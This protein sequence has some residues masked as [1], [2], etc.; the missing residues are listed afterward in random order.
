M[1]SGIS[2]EHPYTL[3]N[4]P[5]GSGKTTAISNSIKKLLETTEKRILCITFTNRATEQLALKIED[6]RVDI[7][8][9]HSFV[10]DI[11]VPF[12]KKKE[13]LNLYRDL[14][15][16]KINQIFNSTDRKDIERIE[17]Y[18]N[19]KNIS[20]EVNLDISIVINNL[21]EIYYNE[22]QFSSY[23]YGGLSHDDLLYFAKEVFH[24]FTKINKILSQKYSHIF[25]D[26]YQDTKS[27]I[28][29]LFYNATFGTSTRLILM[30]D[31]MQQIYSDSVEEFQTTLDNTFYKDTSL[32][33]NWRS[34]KYI[35]TVLNNLYFDAT[36]K[37]EPMQKGGQLPTIHIVRNMN[38]IEVLDGALQLVLYNSDMFDFIGSG[39][40]FRAF[41][42]K[43]KIY[44]K[45]S[46]KQ[47]LT[48]MSMENP[49]ELMIVLIFITDIVEL[50]DQNKFGELI[51]RVTEFRHANG[52]IWKINKHSDKV[53][54]QAQ[55]QEL[56]IVVKQ[57]ISLISLLDY[58]CE[59]KIINT[60][61]IE[62]VM[63]NINENEKFKEKI[64]PVK[65]IQFKNCYN[66]C[67]KQTI[68]TQHAV[69]G[70]GHNAVL[71]KISDGSNP[72]IQMYTF[73]ELWS[74][75]S[76]DYRNIK[77]IQNELKVLK[78]EYS[79][80]LGFSL[81][82]SNI[83]K[84]VFE[85]QSDKLNAFLNDSVS[86]L[87]CSQYLYDCILAKDYENFVN[88][89]NV[90]NYKKCLSALNKLEGII[91]AYKLFYVGCSRAREKL[92]VY[93]LSEK[94]SCFKDLF[95]EQMESIGFKIACL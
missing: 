67:K 50:F 91:P 61:H 77:K 68:S 17:K 83:N 81:S 23:L 25:I 20:D 3:V 47:I 92:D 11:M 2:F 44:D 27:E 19:R 78:C 56:S 15:K 55:L 18:R 42:E 6:D 22:S 69:K 94:I 75:K 93:V 89:E 5:A 84:E 39:D 32:K 31:E 30:G 10:S 28:L 46:S 58:L 90:S 26:E 54:L 36:Y 41:N 45:Y 80:I 73:L 59:N 57:D 63:S 71:L 60:F 8:T 51:K 13:I 62:E 37:Q 64:I 16:E 65:Y 88:R 12:F 40:L 79:N 86:V 82:G 70:E 9:I 66:E 53:K 24:K 35:V 85:G 1:A 49:D 74:R 38:E 87:K 34:T 52:E 4:A 48:D 7:S 72:N 43:Y 29:D 14:F 76:F 33:K 95:V 21:S